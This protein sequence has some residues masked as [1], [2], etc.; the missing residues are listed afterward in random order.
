MKTGFKDALEIKEG[1]K[2]KK[3]WSFECPPYDE[4]TSCFVNAGTNYGVGHKTPVGK[5]NA[6]N[7]GAI[8]FGRP[9]TL[10]T[11]YVYNGKPGLFESKEEE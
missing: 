4:R 10:E 3:P 7:K 9:N 2:P 5:F 11:D 6:S 1:H 8:P